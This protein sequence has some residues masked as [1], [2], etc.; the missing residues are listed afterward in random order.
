MLITPIRSILE[1]ARGEYSLL[2]LKPAFTKARYL[3][4]INKVPFLFFRVISNA[5]RLAIYFKHGQEGGFIALS[6]NS[7]SS[8]KQLRDLS[9]SLSYQTYR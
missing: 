4:I 5:A 3:K 7:A 1:I 6:E 2:L 9:R 8:E